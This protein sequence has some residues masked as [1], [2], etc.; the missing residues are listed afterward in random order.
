[1]SESTKINVENLLVSHREPDLNVTFV[2]QLII[3]FPD[4]YACL[5]RD[6]EG[7]YHHDEELEDQAR[8]PSSSQEAQME[9][10]LTPTS[11]SEISA[12]H[13]H[14]EGIVQEKSVESES[15]K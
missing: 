1:M 7:N 10:K 2:S 13:V 11:H 14:H 4:D 12:S 5:Q 15:T 8:A 3:P 6:L 9:E